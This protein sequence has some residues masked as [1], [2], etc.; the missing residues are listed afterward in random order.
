M[1][2]NHALTDPD[3]EHFVRE[4][5]SNLTAYPSYYAHM[6]PANAQGPGPA[7]LSVP[8]ALGAGE[9]TRRLADGEWVIDLRNRVA[10]A[11]NH[12]KG[13]VSFE[14]G[15]GGSFT[16]FL[17][18]VLPWHEQLTLVGSHSDVEDAIR[19]LSRI[20]IDSPD[21]AVGTEPHA[22]AP[23]PHGEAEP[24]PIR[25]RYRAAAGLAL[26]QALEQLSRR[27]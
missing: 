6:S 5:I 21:A 23:N 25:W 4:L 3:E 19:D 1:T 8:Q 24:L 16:T 20:G 15:D 17:G 18:W 9:L 2:A 27:S 14:Y 12:L 26:S 13:A 22:L 7:N 10:F 11:S